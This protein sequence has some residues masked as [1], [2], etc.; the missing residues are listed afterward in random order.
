MGYLSC[1]GERRS[2]GEREAEQLEGDAFKVC[3][4]A[5]Q[6]L[7]VEGLAAVALSLPQLLVEPQSHACRPAPDGQAVA[8]RQLEPVRAENIYVF[9]LL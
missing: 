1:C 3:I 6:R 4:G 7:V 8:Q 2:G 9:A 5:V